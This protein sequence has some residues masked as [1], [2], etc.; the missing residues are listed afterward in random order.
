MSELNP[1][2]V[3]AILRRAGVEGAAAEAVL[4]VD[5]L[6]QGWRRRMAKRE[7]GHRALVELGID[8]DLAQFD[9]LVAIDAPANEFGETEGETM[10]STVAERLRIDPSR[11]SRVV[12]EM[13]DLGFA[14]R[15]VSQ[16]DARR[17]IIR[18][19]ARGEAV[20]Q[21]VRIYRF[22]LLGD[23]LSEW[24]E[25]ELDT[26]LPQLERFSAWADDAGA[27]RQRFDKQIN[28]LAQSLRTTE[29]A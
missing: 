7:L 27:R 5:A 1:K 26:F 15:G 17:A 23:Y 10:V 28:A 8:L 9:V 22:L 12:S 4:R 16:A 3:V 6:M 20:V 11:A 24:T 25:Q 21:A 18:L 2:E 14:V 29:P 13:V 19:T